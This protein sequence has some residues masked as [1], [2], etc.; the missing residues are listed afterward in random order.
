MK[1]SKA[2]WNVLK[3]RLNTRFKREVVRNYPVA[4]FMEPNL[5][6]NLRCPACP[7]GLRLN[8]RPTVSVKE[9]LF[10]A[11]IDEVGDYLF[12]LYMY[13]WGEPLLHKQTPELI[14]YAK[15]KD[16][17]IIMSTNL[18]LKLTDD[19]L[20]RLV[21]SG[22]DVLTV[23]LDGMTAETYSKYRRGGDFELVRENVRRIKAIKDRLG[24]STPK[25]VWQ[26]LVFRHN[27]HEVEQARAEYKA[28]GADEITVGAAIMPLEPHD[29]GFEPST[30]PAY[31]MYQPEHFVQTESKRQLNS[32]RACSW[33]YGVFVL[34]PNGRVS[35]CCA[36]PSEKHDFGEF[37]PETKFFDVWNNDK[38]R[39]AR[40]LFVEWGKKSR[41]GGSN[42]ARKKGTGEL[43][44]GMAVRAAEAMTDDK[45][46]CQKCPIPHMQNYTDGIINETAQ[47]MINSLGVEKSVGKRARALLNYLLMGA[48]NGRSVIHLGVGKV[49][50][51]F[52]LK[53][54]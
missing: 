7:T 30:I 43:V 5:L 13:N 12:Q 21:R 54:Q 24:V 39:R 2:Y 8:L 52:H 16:I 42:G 33:L 25:I 11:A 17:S 44:D 32:D 29:E 50:Q 48:P 15:A 34:N 20:E 3:L 45:L 18:S 10:K 31:N 27:E 46:I 40:H 36:V 35:P 14:S 41:K 19:Y 4:A 1:K 37:T 9:E 28:W 51:F 23:S 49:R 26:F 53:N 22:L 38:F 47:G 6:C